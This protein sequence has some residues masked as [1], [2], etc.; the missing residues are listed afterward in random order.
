MDVKTKTVCFTGHRK[1]PSEK[2]SAVVLRLEKT[3]IE[4]IEQ[5]YLFFETG[6]ALGFDTIAAQA[7]L[8]LR[9]IYPKIKL[10]LVLPCLSQAK[11]WSDFDKVI[12]ED[13]KAN[14]DKV[15]YISQTYTNGCM[16]KRNRYLVD[17]SNICICYLTAQSGGTVY[18][19]K[20]ARCK[21]VRIINVV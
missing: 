7:V 18:T 20:Y 6:G 15:V 13:I 2:I 3:I 16:F 11:N 14:A 4:L 21:N 10:I 1:I 9:S 19:V 5:G 8:K 17:N 12:Y